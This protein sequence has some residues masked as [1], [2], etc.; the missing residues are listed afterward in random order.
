MKK[1]RNRLQ[2]LMKENTTVI[3]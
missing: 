3:E 2:E 1:I